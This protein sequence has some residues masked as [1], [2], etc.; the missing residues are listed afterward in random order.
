MSVVN[1]KIN[2]VKTPL[3]Y[4][5]GQPLL[6]WQVESEA[7]TQAEAAVRVWSDFPAD[8]P[9]WECRGDLNW[10]CTKLELGTLLPRTRYYVQVE[11]TDDTGTVHTGETWFETGKL[12]ESWQAKWIGCDCETPWAPVFSGNFETSEKV[13]QARLYMVGLGVY[14]ARLNGQ[15][16]SGEYLAP[17]FWYYEKEAPYQSYDV[18]ELIRGHNTLDVTLG[19]GWYKGR[20]GLEHKPYGDRYA[21][22]AELHLQFTDGST[23][24]FIT[25][26]NWRWKD[27]DISAS[28]GIYDGEILDRL[29]HENEENASRPVRVISAP[30]AVRERLNPPVVESMCLNVA[31]VIHTPAGETVLDFGQNHTGLLRFKADLPKGTE[32]HFDFGEVLQQGNFYNDNYRS[33]LGGFTYRSSGIAERVCQS[34]TFFGFRYVRVTGWPGELNPGDFESPVLHT[35]LDRTGYLT[36]G[37]KLLNR[38]YENVLWGQRSNFLSIP[39]DCPQRDERLG[40]TGD[41][42]VFSPTACYNMDCRAFY[43]SFLNFLRLDQQDNGG[44]I[45]TCL[46]RSPGFIS[47]AI[48]GDAATI[49]PETLLRFSGSLDE[50]ASYYPMMKDWVDYV[51]AQSHNYLYGIDQLGDWLALDGVTTQSFK[52]GTDDTYL[53]SIYWMNSA[54]IVA[55]FAQRLGYGEDAKN[56]AA[57]AENIRSAV[58]DT[59]FTASGRLSVDTQA[60]YITALKFGLW[61]DKD[62]LIKQFMRRMRFDGFEIRCGFAGAPLM[63]SVLAEHGMEDLACDLLLQKGFPGWMYC[64]ELGATTIWERWNSL[65]PD[66]TCSGTGMNSLNHYA[67]GSVMEYV[68]GHL[69]GLRPGRQGFRTTVIAPKPDIRLGHMECTLETV[70]GK[71]VS[72][73]HICENGELSVHLEIPFGCS[74]EVTLPRRG[75]ESLTLTAGSYDF[76]YMPDRDY[77]AVYSLDTRL[78]ALA[79]DEAAQGILLQEAPALFGVLKESNREFTTQTFRELSNAFFLGMTPQKIEALV[80]RLSQLRY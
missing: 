1:L 74:A 48:W 78:G 36:T 47:C 39:T 18:T 76:A 73:W 33:A 56:Y 26:E 31:E 57:L 61:R 42:Q 68:Y 30:L 53:G 70:S 25:D 14:T 79:E 52:G 16:V 58:L 75:K 9:L 40:W 35:Q 37:N 46:P 19:N 41:A 27:S 17:G 62:V 23:Q 2:G 24:I 63:C 29:A 8:D 49:I 72:N 64:V 12:Q 38:L 21:L 65:L 15:N 51:A 59:Y 45:A 54:R 60:A 28:N 5:L 22:L 34:F 55:E 80:D 4:D 10:E 71:F 20:F 32:I 67:Y 43:R 69:A 50:I 44:G 6:S 77:R 3:G 13:I 7:S 66:G 11:V